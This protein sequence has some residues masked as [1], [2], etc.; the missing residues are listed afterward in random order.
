MLTESMKQFENKVKSTISEF[1]LAGKKDKI[2]VACSG[3]KDSTTTLYLLKKFGYD[4]EALIIDLLIGEWSEK[5]LE[6][7]R[8]FC[9][10]HGIKLHVISMRTEFGCS[11]CY[12]RSN[13][14]AKT[15]L[16]NCAICG[17]I[18]RWILNKKARELGADKIATGHNL[19]DE[20]ETVMMNLFA[21]N[22]EISL[23]AGPKNG[24]VMDKK[25]VQRIK[26][27]YF[28]TNREIREYSE[29]MKFPVLYKPCPCST[30]AFRREIRKW[31]AV[32][33][34]QEP[35]I[36]A[37]IVKNFLVLLPELR[38]SVN[39][40]KKLRYCRSCGEPSRND[41][42][43]ACGLMGLLRPEAK[44]SFLEEVSA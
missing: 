10:E 16:S 41:I 5:N 20:A 31:L 13:I 40:V 42:C 4:V 11:M 23:G 39:P 7:V 26:P 15:K 6:N 32:L 28:C 1:D 37:D 2:L 24:L 18:K 29:A 17:V 44:A 36:K 30:D 14:Q 22:I 34:K 9:R 27:L 35:E 3:G 12:I 43:R 21:G 33:E 38:K 19:D 8:N 25:F